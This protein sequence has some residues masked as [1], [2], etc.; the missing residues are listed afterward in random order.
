VSHTTSCSYYDVYSSKTYLDLICEHQC[1][2][3]GETKYPTFLTLLLL[4]VR[5]WIR[6]AGSH[7]YGSGY[8]EVA[9]M[10]TKRWPPPR[11]L[12]G[13]FLCVALNFIPYAFRV[14]GAKWTRCGYLEV[15]P[16]DIKR[17]SPTTCV[18]WYFAQCGT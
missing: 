15:T 12:C 5:C 17:R 18:V 6:K 13:T 11:A 10:D 2:N 14:T 16:T 1:P 9:P 3:E 4:C 8:Q 7:R